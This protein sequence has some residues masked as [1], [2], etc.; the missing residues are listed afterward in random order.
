MFVVGGGPAGLAAAIAARQHGLEVT[1]ADAAEP[2]IDKPCGEGVMPDGVTALRMLGVLVGR[3][4]GFPFHGIRFVDGGL[5]AEALFPEGCGLGIRRTILHQCLIRHALALGVVMCW[6]SPVRVLAPE[7]IRLDGRIIQSRWLVGADGQQSRIRHWG[8]LG[9]LMG[10]KRRLGFRQHFRVRPW[11]DLV[12]VHWHTRCQAYVTPV[13]PN[14]VCVALIGTEPSLRMA[15]LPTLFPTLGTRLK[16]AQAID[17]MAGTISACTSLPS[18]VHNNLAL[19]GDA[20]GTVDAISGEGLSLA[21]RQAIALGEALAKN[22]LMVYQSAHKRIKRLSHLM[23][24]MVLT[25]DGRAWL[26]HRALRALAGRP[27]VFARLLAVHVGALP[28]AAIGLNTILSFAWHLAIS[29]AGAG[30]SLT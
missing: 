2:P 12:E 3:E 18:V 6:G 13:R 15:Q 7:D 28:P 17:T 11:T 27:P 24:R 16:G 10:G 9:P 14:E 8:G 5:S 29:G 19:V 30:R 4:E 22:D 21:F 1:V 26:R 25:M 23:A 20:S